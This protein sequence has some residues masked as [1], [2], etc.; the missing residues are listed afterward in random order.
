MCL[1]GQ[2][3]IVVVL[4]PEEVENAAA[5]KVAAITGIESLGGGAKVLLCCAALRC[6]IQITLRC[7]DLCCVAL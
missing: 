6:Q 3:K 1:A 7:A 5:Q 2:A 4:H